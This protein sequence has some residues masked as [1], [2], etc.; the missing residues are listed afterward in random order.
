MTLQNDA[1]AH[2]AT[3]CSGLIDDVVLLRPKVN[4]AWHTYVET[5]RTHKETIALLSPQEWQE[6]LTVL[7]QD[8]LATVQD[9]VQIDNSDAQAMQQF[10][11]AATQTPDQLTDWP[12]SLLDDQWAEMMRTMAAEL[13]SLAKAHAQAQN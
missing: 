11:A 10:A 12:E 5:L 2:N 9:Q 3:V 13:R 7:W 1:I 4:E 8:A 6:R